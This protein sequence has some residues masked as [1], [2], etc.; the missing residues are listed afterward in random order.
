MLLGKWRATRFLDE[1][2]N[3]SQIKYLIIQTP[4]ERTQPALKREKLI[5]LNNNKI[6]LFIF[7]TSDLRLKRFCFLKTLIIWENTNALML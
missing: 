3:M 1:F 2:F 6:M 7:N 4:H 5:D